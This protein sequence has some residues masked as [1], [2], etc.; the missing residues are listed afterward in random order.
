MVLHLSMA[1]RPGA[2]EAAWG[3]PPG[4]DAGQRRGPPSRRGRGAAT[5]ASLCRSCSCF[6]PPLHEDC[7]G[8]FA[9]FGHNLLPIGGHD[10]S[11]AP[12]IAAESSRS[13]YPSTTAPAPSQTDPRHRT[14]STRTRGRRGGRSSVRRMVRIGAQRH[15]AETTTSPF[16]SRSPL[17]VACAGTDGRE[18]G[19]WLG[20]SQAAV[21]PVVG[22]LAGGGGMA[23][24]A[25]ILF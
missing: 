6:A 21:V 15:Q 12:S 4:G 11:C 22:A 24:P 8:A 18:R 20:G 2:W 10:L 3:L 7:T 9:V 19:C 23:T 16:C 5:G 14:S 1:P 25:V 13:T 17:Q